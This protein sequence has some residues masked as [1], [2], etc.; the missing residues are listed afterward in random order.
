MLVFGPFAL[1][2]DKGTLLRRGEPVALGRRGVRLLDALL[3]R[4]GEI[5]T[6]T[7]L[8]D[9]GWHGS[10]VEESNLSVQIALLRRA[11]GSPPDGGEWIATIPRIGYRFLG[12]SHERG[13]QTAQR[14]TQPSLA[15]LPLTNL[16]SD[17][18]QAYFAD[19]LVDDVITML[20]KLSG[21]VVIARS[22]SFSYKGLSTDIRLVARDLGVR[23]VMA[24]S[25]RRNGNRLRIVA[26]LN[27]GE[28]GVQL[29]AESYDREFADIFGVQEE[30]ARKIVGELSI[31]LSPTG[32]AQ[33]PGIASTGT[34]S[35][36]AYNCFLRG[37]AMQRGATQNAQVLKRT[38]ELFRQAI[39]H[40]PAYAAPYAALGMSCAHAFCNRWT[41][42]PD[43][44]LAEAGTLVDEAI[45]RDPNDP[46]SHGVAALVSMYRK[47]YER[48]AFEVETSLSLNPNFAPSISLRGI[49]NMYSGRA[50]AAIDDIE[51][52]M[53]LDPLFTHVYIHHLGVAYF[54]ARKYETAAALLR[55]RILL[56]PDTDISRACLAAVLGLLGDVDGARQV[57]S[58]LMAINPDYSFAEGI[59]RMPF[60]N[61]EDLGRIRSGLLMAGLPI[62][63]SA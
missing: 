36:D 27:D 41:D 34:S 7:E 1:D 47:D 2:P 49:L 25:V 58:E 9:A 50:Q 51:R 55:E 37:R 5:L 56:A 46:F 30:V 39:V 33:W 22:S 48:W 28:T 13:G 6:K 42:D 11:L 16:S 57:W 20:S 40:D 15:V 32:A 53:R 12:S 24:G 4:P 60:K 29:W 10:A 3:K 21:L 43:G 8:M 63:R 62:E 52:A 19:G 26:Q 45:N 59:G 35:I 17:L 38:T 18:E 23:F 44:S 14:E 31:A 61:P 54:F